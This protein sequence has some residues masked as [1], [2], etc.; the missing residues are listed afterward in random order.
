VRAN[1]AATTSA[2]RHAGTPAKSS[3]NR[4]AAGSPDA[5]LNICS[6]SFVEAFK[7]APN[8]SKSSPLLLPLLPLLLPALLPLLRASEMTNPACLCNPG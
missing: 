1:A 3:N 5:A 8:C 6:S 2:A 7:A 4:R